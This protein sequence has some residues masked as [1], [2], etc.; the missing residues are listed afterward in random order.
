MTGVGEYRQVSFFLNGGDGGKVDNNKLRLITSKEIVKKIKTS[1]LPKAIVT[2]YPTFD[3]LE[4]EV[5]IIN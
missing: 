4:I 5:S 3:A 1:L 2:E